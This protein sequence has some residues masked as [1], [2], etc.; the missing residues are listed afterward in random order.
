[1]IDDSRL[2]MHKARLDETRFDRNSNVSSQKEN[3]LLLPT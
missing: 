2:E 3:D 1:M